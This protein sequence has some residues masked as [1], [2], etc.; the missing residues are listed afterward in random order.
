MDKAK[1][2]ELQARLHQL[3]NAPKGGPTF[4]LGEGRIAQAEARRRRNEIKNLKK[5]TP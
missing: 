4:R 2:Q 3:K 1:A 5:E